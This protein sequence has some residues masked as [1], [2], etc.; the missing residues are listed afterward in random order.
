MRANGADVGALADVDEQRRANADRL[1]AG[2]LHGGTS[3]DVWTN[4]L[5]LF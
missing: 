2:Q 3:L 1:Q 4:G 5:D